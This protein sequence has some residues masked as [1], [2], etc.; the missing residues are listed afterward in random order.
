VRWQL[1]V[2]QPGARLL[3]HAEGKKQVRAVLERIDAIE[4]QGI[5]PTAV[6]P[7]YWRMLANRLAT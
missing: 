3:L 7:A 5:V 6:S 2:M 4:A 1:L